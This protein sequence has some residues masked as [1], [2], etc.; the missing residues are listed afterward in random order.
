VDVH[1]IK[2]KHEGGTNDA[3]NL[4]VVCPTCHRAAH[5]GAYSKRILRQFRSR[6]RKQV[7]HLVLSKTLLAKVQDEEIWTFIYD[8]CVSRQYRRAKYLKLEPDELYLIVFDFVK[9]GLVVDPNDSNPVLLNEQESLSLPS[10]EVVTN[11]FRMLF[12]E[13]WQS[14]QVSFPRQY[15][16][17]RSDVVGSLASLQEDKSL[18]ARRFLSEFKRGVRRVIHRGMRSSRH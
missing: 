2:P 14:A 12:L 4:I 7:Q 9:V 18:Q 1:H 11:P 16:L 6:H 15:F 13:Q 10:V 17:V 5:N 8:H 3:S